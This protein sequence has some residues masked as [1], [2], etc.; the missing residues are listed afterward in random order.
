[1]NDW[2]GKHPVPY[3]FFYSFNTASG[4]NL[5]WFWKKW[6]FG[7][8]YPDLSI[9]KVEK[10]GNNFKIK[11]ENKG[12]LPLPVYLNIFY[13]NGKKSTQKFTAEV[14]KDG[15]KEKEFIINTSFCIYFKN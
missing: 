6:F 15:N 10:S 1:M 14:W 13:K 12:G 7:W 4:K 2:N 3:D 9:N 5:D 8:E 11:I